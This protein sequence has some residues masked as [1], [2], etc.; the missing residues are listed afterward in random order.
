MSATAPQEGA[1]TVELPLWA[2]L[3]WQ[4]VLITLAFL[5]YFGVRGATE[6]S[7]SAA[8]ANAARLTDIQER[9]GI[10]WEP[11][12]QS[13]IA[14]HQ[15]MIAL[16]NWVYIWGHWPA[17]GVVV[18]WLFVRHRYGFYLLR[19]A[20]FISGAIG[21]I[22]FLSIPMAP[23]RLVDDLNII[24]TVT[25]QSKAYR[26]LQ[27]P[28]LVNQYAAFPSLHFG[29]NML[30]GIVLFRYAPYFWVKVIAV[31]LPA[32]MAAAVVLTANHY[33]LD[34][35][36]GT[37]VALLGLWIAIRLRDSGKGD[38][39]RAALAPR[40]AFRRWNGRQTRRSASHS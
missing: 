6:G 34:V 10:M 5:V 26:T 20:I 38:Q 40:L 23:P 8:L 19:N 1:R 28:G 17:I 37:I 31:A 39:I 9:L 18:V 29:F 30:M 32:A 25:E 3:V 14:D 27:P 22:F 13:L 2:E 21:L 4:A 11:G 16:F 12:L 7:E 15:W 33:V 35:L 36:G 24:D